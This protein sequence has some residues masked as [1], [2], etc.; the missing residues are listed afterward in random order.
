MDSEQPDPQRSTPEPAQ[1]VI[2]PTIAQ[3]IEQHSDR[4]TTTV[5]AFRAELDHQLQAP[6]SETIELGSDALAPLPASHRA[7]H[8]LPVASEPA[9]RLLAHPR[10]SGGG[11]KPGTPIAP[12]L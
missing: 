12:L 10:R 4:F 2:L 3:L 8:Q 9:T 6:G 7:P 1:P 11:T 5:Q